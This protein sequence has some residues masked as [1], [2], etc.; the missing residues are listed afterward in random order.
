MECL[1]QKKL[2][3]YKEWWGV[4]VRFVIRFLV[5]VDSGL[6]Q[7]TPFGLVMLSA[8]QLLALG[9]ESLLIKWYPGWFLLRW[10]SIQNLVQWLNFQK[11]CILFLGRVMR[12][13]NSGTESSLPN[14]VVL[15]IVRILYV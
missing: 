12:C 1:P 8:N 3:Y 13:K 6:V 11:T 7:H 5:Q 14:R 9:H 4:A 10:L 15:S 2:I